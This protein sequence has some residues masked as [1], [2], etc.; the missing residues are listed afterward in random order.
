MPR[1]SIVIPVVGNPNRLDD[2]LVSILENRP[3]DCEILVVHNEPYNDP[4]DLAGEVQFLQARPRAGFVECLN[5]GLLA[6]R[7]PVVNAVACGVE[8]RAGWADAALPHFRQPEIA[9]VT[10]VVTHRAD[11]GKVVS[12]GLGYGDEGIAWRIGRGRTT[13]EVA[14]ARDELCGPDALTAFYRTSAVHAIGGFSSLKHAALATIDTAL[15]LQRAGFRC[16]ME[17]ECMAC[18]DPA[19]VCEQP[20]FRHGRDAERLFWRWAS[21]HGR[22]RSIAV[23]AALVAGE[24]VIGLWRP[25]ML[26]QLAGRAGGAI[27]AVLARRQEP[28]K[29][30]AVAETPSVVAAPHFDMAKF[31]EEQTPARAA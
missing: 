21:H 31:R 6:A 10:A 17:P 30:A 4:Y 27:L 12:A 3:A 15:S 20:G 2:T 1:L 8:V 7:S 13:A 26:L 28:S 9:A 25:S 11:P 22:V 14:D 19:M 5:L 24:C 23:H 29:A 18:V 16:A